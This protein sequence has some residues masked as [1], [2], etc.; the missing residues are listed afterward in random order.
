MAL[1]LAL[2]RDGSSRRSPGRPLS[3]WRPKSAHSTPVPSSVSRTVAETTMSPCIAQRH[4][5]GDHVHDD[6]TH[7]PGAQLDLANVDRGPDIDAQ[8]G[9]CTANRER[10]AD[11]LLGAVEQSDDAVAAGLDQAPAVL[12]DD[13]LGQRVS[14]ARVV[15]QPV[16]GAKLH[17]LCGRVDDVGHEHGAERAPAGRSLALGEFAQSLEIDAHEGHVAHDPGV[18]AGRDL[19]NVAFAELE[20]DMSSAI[21]MRSVPA[22]AMPT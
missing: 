22:K 18:M 21:C 10:R 15:L 2:R 5:P 12:V 8:G 3:S 11:R 20:L 7:V 16:L 14:L 19:E 9:H 1:G 17:R 6:A 13:A 4:H